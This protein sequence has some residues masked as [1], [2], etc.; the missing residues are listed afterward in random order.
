MH[1]D[2]PRAVLAALKRY[3]RDLGLEWDQVGRCWWFTER[4]RRSWR[5]VHADG[6]VARA[7]VTVDEALA[8]VKA[9]DNRASGAARLREMARAREQRLRGEALDGETAMDSARREAAGRARTWL[10]GP[11]PWVGPAAAPAVA[12]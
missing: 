4:G 9:A 5:Y 3:D 11:Q 7:D 6:T 2:A 1:R 10:N 12:S 8:L